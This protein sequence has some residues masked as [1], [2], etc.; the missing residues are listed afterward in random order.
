[1]TRSAISI[2]ATEHV[3]RELRLAGR[4][5]LAVMLVFLGACGLRL[6]SPVAKGQR[7]A[8]AQPPPTPP[9]T[10]VRSTSDTKTTRIVEVREGV[11]KDA[12][13]KMVSD[14]LAQRYTVDVSDPR[15]GFLMTAWQSSVGQNGVPDL[16]YRVRVVVRFLGVGEEWK[17]ISVRAD[18]N[19]QRLDEWDVGFDVA[20]LEAV[21]AELRLMLG[22]RPEAAPPPG[23]IK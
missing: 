16:R 17:Q 3:A 22:K 10:F 13:F 4:A 12:A 19:W 20:A 1:M 23:T 7:P 21:A 5:A 8:A 18:A 6:Q 11:K 15:A 2:R 14:M 9:E